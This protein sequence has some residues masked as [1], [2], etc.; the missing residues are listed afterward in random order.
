[1]AQVGVTDGIWEVKGLL[2]AEEC[3]RYI[4]ATE[5][6]GYEPATISTRNG[7]VLALDQRNNGR[8][9]VDDAELATEIWLRLSPHVPGVLDGRQASGLNE[10]FRY[11][12]Y[13]P[14][15]SFKGALSLIEWVLGGSGALREA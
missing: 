14:G 13:T 10:R 15:Q 8:L 5:E 9:I 11:Y 1:M 3:A 12:R 6:R 2:A 7:D 4:A